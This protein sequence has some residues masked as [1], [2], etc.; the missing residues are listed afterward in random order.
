[1]SLD[2]LLRRGFIAFRF[3]L[4][5]SVECLEGEGVTVHGTVA[6]LVSSVVDLAS[7]EVAN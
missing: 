1:M 4:C 3:P 6:L 7:P 5:G 2:L